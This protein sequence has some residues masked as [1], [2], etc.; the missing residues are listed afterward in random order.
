MG[1]EPGLTGQVEI[2]V[3]PETFAGAFGNVGIDVLATLYVL[4]AFEQAAGMAV[5][6][7]LAENQAT[8]GTHL[9]MDHYAPTPG[10]MTVTVKA[11]LEEVDGRRLSYAIEVR[12]EIEVVATG[13]HDRYIVERDWFLQRIED[14]RKKF[15]EM[16]SE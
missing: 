14:K 16:K 5:M 1:I 10:G 4:A 8:V 12:D 2:A 15:A 7:F 9:S 3:T 6:P 11:T 13:R